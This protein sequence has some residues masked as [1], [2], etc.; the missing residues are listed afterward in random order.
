L[1]PKGDNVEEEGFHR[2][3][4]SLHSPRLTIKLVVIASAPSAGGMPLAA[5]PYE[6]IASTYLPDFTSFNSW[7]QDVFL[8]FSTSQDDKRHSK[9]MTPR[10]VGRD[11]DF[12]SNT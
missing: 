4:S 1:I 6:D 3:K 12:K 9:C 8:D 2:D 11:C 7:L 10:K 5:S